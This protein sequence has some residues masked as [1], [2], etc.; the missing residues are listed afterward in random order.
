MIVKEAI[1]PLDAARSFNAVILLAQ[2]IIP[3][4]ER[5]KATLLNDGSYLISIGY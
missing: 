1:S 2:D 4:L 3:S 5:N